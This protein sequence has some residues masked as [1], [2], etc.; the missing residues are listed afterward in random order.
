VLCFNV[1]SFVMSFGRLISKMEV[2]QRASAI[3]RPLWPNERSLYANERELMA[4]VMMLMPI[5]CQVR[6]C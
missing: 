4:D 2:Q 1:C 3:V 5:S 6:D